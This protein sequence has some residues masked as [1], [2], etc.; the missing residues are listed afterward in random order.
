MRVLVI[1][2]E[3]SM[4]Q[5]IQRFLSRTGDHEVMTAESASDAFFLLSSFRGAF[6]V[7][8]CDVHLAGMDAKEFVSRLGPRD[9]ARVVLMTGGSCGSDDEAF[10]SEREVL[11]KPFSGERLQA[12]IDAVADRAA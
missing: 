12:V 5:V 9:A 10:L 2:D 7:I 4:L 11:L 1:D 3:K 8:L 6:D